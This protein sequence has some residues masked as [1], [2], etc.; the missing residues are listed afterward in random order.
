MDTFQPSSSPT[1][2][3]AEFLS[4][5]VQGSSLSL[6]PLPAFVLRPV[7]VHSQ[8]SSPRCSN[9]LSFSCVF[10]LLLVVMIVLSS[11]LVW[12]ESHSQSQHTVDI[13]T[14]TFHNDLLQHI[15]DKL[16]ATFNQPI[17]VTSYLARSFAQ[18]VF[19]DNSTTAPYL[20]SGFT[21]ELELLLSLFPNLQSLGA[22]SVLQYNVGMQ[23]D[24]FAVD[25]WTVVQGV[26]TPAF[27]SSVLHYYNY[28]TPRNA[29]FPAN[30]FVQDY[31]S[32]WNMTAA[33]IQQQLL[34]QVSV[35][36]T[37]TDLSNRPIW[38]RGKQLPQN[39][40]GWTRPYR[41]A[42]LQAANTGFAAVRQV[43]LVRD[44]TSP[45]VVYATT[46]LTTIDALLGDLYVGDNGVTFIVQA[47]GYIVSSSNSQWTLATL[48]SKYVEDLVPVQGSPD[49]LLSAIGTT[50]AASNFIGDY[51][52]NLTGP[53]PDFCLSTTS[54]T[55]LRDVPLSIGGATYHLQAQSL[56]ALHLD[57][58]ITVLTYD[59]DYN[60]NIRQSDKQASI[61]VAVVAVCSIVLG[62][63]LALAVHRPFHRII[64]AMN[65]LSST[66]LLAWE[67]APG[68]VASDQVNEIRVDSDDNNATSNRISQQSSCISQIIRT[69]QTLFSF[70]AARV[71]T[72]WEVRMLQD[73]FASMLSALE[74]SSDENRASNDAKKR[75]FRYIFHEVRVPLNAVVLSVEQLHH[76]YEIRHIS[77]SVGTA[78]P[79][80]PDLSPVSP[81]Q[82]DEEVGELLEVLTE[83]SQAMVR[84]LNDVLSLQ[85]IEEGAAEWKSER[86]VLDE[87]VIGLRRSSALGLESKHTIFDLKLNNHHWD[88]HRRSVSENRQLASALALS[89]LLPYY[90]LTSD[91]YRLRQIL[92]N[93]LS[94]AIKFTPE[95]GSIELN[96]HIPH[97]PDHSTLPTRSTTAPFSDTLL[98]VRF[99]V[100]DSGSGL[101]EAERVRLFQPYTQLSAGSTDREN[102]GSGLGLSICRTLVAQ[103]GGSIGIESVK[104]L[105]STFWFELPLYVRLTQVSPSSAAAIISGPFMTSS[106]DALTVSSSLAQPNNSPGATTIS[107]SAARS[108]NPVVS[109]VGERLCVMVV[110]DQTA[111]LK[112][113]AATLRSLGCDVLLARDGVECLELFNIPSPPATVWRGQDVDAELTK[114]W[115]MDVHVPCDVVLMD[116]FMPRLSGVQTVKLL[117]AVGVLVPVIGCTGNAM[118]E[119]M[120]EFEQAGATSVLSKPVSRSALKGI[121]EQYTA[122][123]PNS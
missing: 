98:L 32:H 48:S 16:T 55:V 44:G 46:F 103:Q 62:A 111:S 76:F 113:M 28:S 116:N 11:V 45:G 107:D 81:V 64:R 51:A 99:S 83:Q 47:S 110:E 31:V 79:F 90:E 69:T 53:I 35:A 6:S 61:I 22:I 63:I 112:L 117:R 106:L 105:G 57:W 115:L 72:L 42:A 74:Q 23:R 17:H 13:L 14:S 123:R 40:V 84:I 100:K 82:M 94:N 58:I 10:V 86:F 71:P 75:F 29:T 38:K 73:S 34:T 121:V 18:D 15:S 95:S 59:D 19:I 93:F 66:N 12:Y 25:Q 1:A 49:P 97:H 4:L 36:A 70:C 3:S 102:V 122:K 20:A 60:R 101:T 114:S 85:K 37:P 77:R 24:T 33:E 30:Q 7:T 109:L 92:S 26:P 21:A 80:T 54:I 91:I 39:T 78:L 2:S 119:D 89:S 43:E 65:T 50:L 104:G 96:I 9:V 27:N 67:T 108:K 8:R 56:F 120:A 88:P 68:T 41:L 52:Y 118:R 87:F 5:P